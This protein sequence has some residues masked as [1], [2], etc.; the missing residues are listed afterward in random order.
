MLLSLSQLYSQVPRQKIVNVGFDM[1]LAHYTL[2]DRM[3]N[4]YNYSAN[5]FSPINIHVYSFGE[6]NMHFGNFYF[7]NPQLTMSQ[8]SDYYQ[9]N[10]L[11]LVDFGAN[12]EYYSRVFSTNKLQGIYLGGAFNFS[13]VYIIEKYENDLWPLGN[14]N[15]QYSYDY[16]ANIAAN[17]LVRYAIRRNVFVFKTGLGLIS[18]AKRP[19][20]YFVKYGGMSSLKNG[21]FFWLSEYQNINTSLIYHY[22]LSE[23]ISFKFEW[24]NCFRSNRF[25]LDFKYLKQS[26]LAGVSYKL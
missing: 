20:D 7:Q 3:L 12:Y 23:R 25:Y 2:S 13:G 15:Y 22:D 4:Y 14:E 19:D 24:L 9:Y 5:T 17:V 10:H 26:Y 16:L 21:E 6:K 18:Y 11:N 8:S 1:G